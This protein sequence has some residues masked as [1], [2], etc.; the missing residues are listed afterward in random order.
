MLREALADLKAALEARDTDGMDSALAKLQSLQ[1][2][3]AAHEAVDAVVQCV[4]FGNFKKA[5]EAVNALKA[6]D[7]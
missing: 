1:L 5:L 3:A 4:L 6:T 2:S 7:A